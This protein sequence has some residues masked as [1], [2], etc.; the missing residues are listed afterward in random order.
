[1]AVARAF[2]A[3]WEATLHAKRFGEM[4]GMFVDDARL[5]FTSPVVHKAYTDPETIH[6]LLRHVVTVL[7]DLTY[8]RTFVEEP[9]SGGV[10]GCAMFFRAKVTAED[11]RRL[12]IEGVDF[13]R[14]AP[15][16]RVVELKVMLRPL[17]PYV[18]VAKKMA[19]LL[20]GASKL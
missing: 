9:G 20:G 3:R 18:Q 6:A 16:G 4:R 2:M 14:L 15:D 10:I 5:R 19:Q 8:T 13:F 11:G 1:M 12:D 17:K 7:E